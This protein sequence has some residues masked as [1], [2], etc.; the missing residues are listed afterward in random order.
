MTSP[1]ARP[2]GFLANFKRLLD[3]AI[4]FRRVQLLA[5]LV[6]TLVGAFAELCTIG[7][8][9]PVLAI[10]AKPEAM[11]TLPIA[12]PLLTALSASLDV[13]PVVAAALFLTFAAVTATL[14][15][16][17]LMWATQKFIFGLQ[18]DLSLEIFRRALRQPYIHYVR[19][20]SSVFLASQQKIA[21][22]VGAVLTPLIQA[23]TSGV[24]AFCMTLFLFML[25]PAAASVAAASIGVTYLAI[26]LYARRQA[27]LMSE[28]LAGV[29]SAR[30]QTMQ[31][32]LGGIRD[33]NLDQSQ[34]VFE[35][36]L[37]AIEDSYRRMVGIA[38]FISSA[39]KLLVEGVAIILVAV[40]AAWFSLQP[41]GVLG[42]LPVLGALALGAQRMLPMVQMVYQGYAQYSMYAGNVTDV[43]ALLDAPIEEIEPIPF[44][45]VKRFDRDIT[46]AK[47]GFHYGNG[48]EALSDVDLVIPKG[49]RVGFVGK[50][51][52]GKST[53]VDVIMGLLPPTRGGLLIDGEAM[54]YASMANWRAQI[55]HVPQAIFLIDDSIAANIA[56]GVDLEDVDFGRVSRAAEHAGLSEFIDSL[57]H[58]LS[59]GVGERGI[60]LSG[61]Q[62]QRIGIARA[63]YKRASV[64]VLDEATS[65]LDDETESAVMESIERLDKN[66][67]VILIAHRLS[68]VARC[69]RIYRLRAGRIV[70]RGSYGE[71]VGVGAATPSPASDT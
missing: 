46:L 40:M 14:V 61:G 37:L 11:A 62:R 64:L 22:V 5:T 6:L 7:A 21:I 19:Q 59:T 28:G 26:T 13:G 15:R 52:S 43:I 3:A 48:P 33:I 63:L 25:N 1:T 55:A 57:E 30:L 16:M 65:A 24:M 60:R 18:Q 27:H 10:A 68:T 66:L 35:A 38:Y 8:V 67:T 41:G 70:A 50:T 51:G 29:H 4:P 69:D 44:D 31:E 34:P 9:L 17:A 47:V 2:R 45:Q 20:N 23:L 12:G 42:A 58:G 39:P 32:M 71:V 36:R 53:L 54:D 56:F 49:A